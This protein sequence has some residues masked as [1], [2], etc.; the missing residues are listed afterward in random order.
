[1]SEIK[2]QVPLELHE[3]YD[4]YREGFEIDDPG[5]R[6][7]HHKA[8]DEMVDNDLAAGVLRSLASID[9]AQ[10]RIKQQREQRK[11]KRFETKELEPA[12]EA[13]IQGLIHQLTE[14]GRLAKGENIVADPSSKENSAKNLETRGFVEIAP[15]FFDQCDDTS[16]NKVFRYNNQ[17]HTEHDKGWEE[18]KLTEYEGLKDLRD[19]LA[20][21]VE[22]SRVNK[23]LDLYPEESAQARDM[24]SN[25]TFIGEKEMEQATEG[26]AA[27]W[28]QYLDGN[29]YSKLCVLADISN[30]E[31]YPGVLKSDRF[32][33]DRILSHFDDEELK[34]YSGRIVN[35][36]DDVNECDPKEVKVVLLDDWTISGKQMRRVFSE[37]IEDPL[38]RHLIERT[39]LNLLVASPER[40][41]E[42]LKVNGV[43]PNN[44]HKLPVKAYYLSHHAPTAKTENKGYVSG[45]HSTV[46]YDF[47]D[48]IDNMRKKLS[49]INIDFDLLPLASI[50]RSYRDHRSSVNI[51]NESLER[52][53]DGN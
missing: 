50:V 15:K 39:E 44:E 6:R 37:L 27:Y 8:I 28:K 46:N 1:M 31:K 23:N 40:V 20:I 22:L 11:Y 24:L 53:H 3:Y 41:H 29:P 18:H 43:K 30:S 42:G 2:S 48:V 9:H 32:V 7:E 12:S 4:L 45:L 5:Q 35:S 33:L 16:R 52:I 10:E 13:A 25:L 47:E 26:I 51:T 14:S 17:P 49:D 34:N 19:F 38:Y 21:F 36:L